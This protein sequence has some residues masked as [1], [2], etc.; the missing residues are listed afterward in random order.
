MTN[1]QKLIIAQREYIKWVN[2]HSHA[3]ES[4]RGKEMLDKITDLEHKIIKEETAPN[5]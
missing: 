2:K 5:I 1:V 4:K 3:D